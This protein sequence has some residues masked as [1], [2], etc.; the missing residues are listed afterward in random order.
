M[1]PNICTCEMML[2]KLMKARQ[3]TTDATVLFADLG[4]YTRLWQTNTSEAISEVLDAFYDE[5]AEAIGT[6]T[7]FSIRRWA[8]PSWPSSIF[9]SAT[10]TTQDGRC[11]PRRTSSGAGPKGCARSEARK[12]LAVRTLA[13]AS[14]SIAAI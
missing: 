7:A 6:V 12:D 14:A 4:G 5:C 10:R 9:P 3:V 13:L 8:T 1:N 11:W 2:A